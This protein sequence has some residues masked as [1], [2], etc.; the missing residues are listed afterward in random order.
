MKKT[1][2]IF[3]AF[4]LCMVSITSIAADVNDQVKGSGIQEDIQQ[5]S[6]IFEVLP[7]YV[8]TPDG[9][10]I[11]PD[12][13]LIVA[14]PNFGNAKKPGCLIKINKDK[15]VRNKLFLLLFNYIYLK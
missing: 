13:D 9:M 15:E 2:A 8:A 4:M 14:C 11:A 10:A 6:K 5:T 12:G 1:L 3:L 7:D